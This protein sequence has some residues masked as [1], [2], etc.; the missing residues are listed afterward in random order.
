MKRTGFLLLFLAFG[1][2]SNSAQAG[3]DFWNNPKETQKIDPA[4][5]QSAGALP[6]CSS[7]C[8]EE[9]A[10]PVG[11]QGPMGP[12]G[13]P[14]SAGLGGVGSPSPT[15]PSVFYSYIGRMDLN[16]YRFPLPPGSTG[17]SSLP[18]SGGSVG[19]VSVTPAESIFHRPSLYY[20]ACVIQTVHSHPYCSGGQPIVL[21]NYTKSDN[22]IFYN[23]ENSFTINRIIY[24]GGDT[25]SIPP[26]LTPTPQQTNVVYMC[27]RALDPPLPIP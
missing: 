8:R 4:A 3:W 10:G 16:C 13:P 9:M 23:W 21:A 5:I 2:F 22:M 27:A 14:G 6:A 1:I 17:G 24:S 25:S 20:D 26:G 19:V 18:V 15:A 11:P 12:E 7:M